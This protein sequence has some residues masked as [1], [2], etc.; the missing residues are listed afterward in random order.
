VRPE[1][2][3]ETGAGLLQRAQL[4][5]A[6]VLESEVNQ[7]GLLDDV[8]NAVTL[9]AQVWEIAHTLTQVDE[10]RIEHEAVPD[11]EDPRIAEILV[12]QAEAL[13]L[14]TGS[15]TRRIRALEDYAVRV[16]AADEALRQWETVQRLSARGEAYRELLARTVRDEF[17]VAE[18]AGLTEEARRI[19]EALR[20]SVSRARKA[21]LALTPDLAVA[22]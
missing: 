12:A 18:I 17:A 6:A 21:G 5:V 2:L 19:E 14:A 15:V 1:D 11:R 9:P 22:S 8:R 7:A 16:R 20:A 4:A 3:S 10:L 13:A